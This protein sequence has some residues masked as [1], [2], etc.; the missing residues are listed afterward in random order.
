MIDNKLQEE[1]RAYQSAQY[2]KESDNLRSLIKKTLEI[3]VVQDDVKP[4]SCGPQ[5][6]VNGVY[7]TI[8]NGVPLKMWTSHTTY[9]IRSREDFIRCLPIE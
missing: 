8:G 4:G 6:S 3:D 9:D 5:A 7:L 1:A 2:E